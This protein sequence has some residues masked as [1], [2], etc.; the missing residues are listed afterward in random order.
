MHTK[1]S[2][3]KQ[4][5]VDPSQ[6][7]S[8]WIGLTRMRNQHT[9]VKVEID[10]S[11]LVFPLQQ[12]P[13]TAVNSRKNLHSVIQKG[14]QPISSAGKNRITAVS[15]DF[16]TPAAPGDYGGLEEWKDLLPRIFTPAAA[17]AA[18]I[19]KKDLLPFRKVLLQIVTFYLIELKNLY[20][21]NL[22]YLFFCIILD[23]I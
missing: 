6:V 4:P 18:T 3:P 1:E 12:Q 5:D 16:L 10:L 21:I 8:V 20:Y 23:N 11:L 17:A 2:Q 15:E 13:E 7:E 22:Y 19:F 9:S 14:K